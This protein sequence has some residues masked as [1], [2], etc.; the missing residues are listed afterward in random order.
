MC[1]CA[2]SLNGIIMPRGVHDE[3][4]GWIFATWNKTQGPLQIKRQ[5]E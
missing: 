4:S 1:V 2:V 5:A 3:K